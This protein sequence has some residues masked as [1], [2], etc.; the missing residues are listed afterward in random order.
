MNPSANPC[1]ALLL[2]ASALRAAVDPGAAWRRRRARRRWPAGPHGDRRRSHRLRQRQ[3]AGARRGRRRGWAPTDAPSARRRRR[4]DAVRPLAA[5]AA[6]GRRDPFRPFTLDPQLRQAD[7]RLCR[8]CRL[9]LAQLICRSVLD[10]PR[11]ARWCRTAAA[12]DTSSRP[13][14]PS[15]AE[16]RRGDN[17]SSRDASSSRSPC[18]TTTATRAGTRS[19]SAMPTDDGGDKAV[20]AAMTGLWIGCGG[21]TVMRVGQF[22][23]CDEVPRRHAPCRS[24]DAPGS[25]RA[26]AGVGCAVAGNRPRT[27]W[28]RPSTSPSRRAAAALDIREIKCRSTTMASSGVFVKLDAPAGGQLTHVHAQ[29]PHPAADRHRAARPGETTSPSATP[30]R[31]TRSC[32]QVRVGKPTAAAASPSM[33]RGRRVADFHRSIRPQRHHRCLP[34]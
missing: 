21:G 17:R 3:R 31:T 11:R 29:I 33:L 6:N 4:C 7:D 32:S 25:R 12:W 9:R 5:V 30:S 2:A 22:V 14:R 16:R 34:R 10:L 1:G 23:G 24:P 28:P 19:S 13:A 8:R 26:P 18:S 15:G 27:D 20:P